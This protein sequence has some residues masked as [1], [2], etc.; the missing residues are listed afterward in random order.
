MGYPVTYNLGP[1]GD[2]VSITMKAA[3]SL[4][5]ADVGKTVALTSASGDTQS[6]VKVGGDGDIVFGR[7][8][9]LEDDITTGE[10]VATVQTSFISD[11]SYTDANADG[12]TLN[13]RVVCDGAGGV[14]A[15]GDIE[16]ATTTPV[17][18]PANLFA[19]PVVLAKDTTD[20]T[21]TIFSV[22]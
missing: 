13:C 14:K 5:A 1:K 8:I 10:K 12:L 4:V 18:L 20:K 2:G 17:T 3:S 7:L 9:K 16:I 21:V 11:V 22:Y 19:L 15:K 6:S